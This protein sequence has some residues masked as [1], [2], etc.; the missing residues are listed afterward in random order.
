MHYPTDYGFIPD[1]LA[2]DG[3]HMDVLVLVHEPTFPGCLITV[4]VIGGLDMA[5][6][7]GSDFKVSAV[8][9]GDS[10]FKHVRASEQ[11]SEHWLR[12]IEAFFA[13]YRLLE[14]KQINVLDWHAAVEA[15]RGIDHCRERYR[16]RSAEQ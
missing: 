12:E 6:E 5:D 4:R 9:D 11:V 10:R 8:P 7:K 1:T 2:G 15:G 13:T 16:Q 3:N 14:P